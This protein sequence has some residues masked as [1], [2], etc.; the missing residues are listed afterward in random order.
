MATVTDTVTTAT[1]LETVV[2]HKQRGG[3][4]EKLARQWLEDHCPYAYYF[5]E[6]ALSHDH[7]TLILEGRVPTYFLKQAL[8]E[9]LGRVPEIVRIDNRV[10]V[11]SSDG[12]SSV[13]PR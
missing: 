10:D 4:L 3:E 9:F 7:G 11:V 13:R 2:L 5:R 1:A 6:V 12:L 8:Q